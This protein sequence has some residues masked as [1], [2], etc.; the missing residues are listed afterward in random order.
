ME[1]TPSSSS[2]ERLNAFRYDCSFLFFTVLPIAIA[3]SDTI[4]FRQ[5]MG[6]IAILQVTLLGIVLLRFISAALRFTS[7]CVIM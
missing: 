4:Q 5:V 2:H 6:I 1:P 3:L 7:L